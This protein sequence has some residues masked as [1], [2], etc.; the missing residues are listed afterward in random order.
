L[1]FKNIN[2]HKFDTTDMKKIILPVLLTF[3]TT[4]AYSQKIEKKGKAIS[5]NQPKLVI[6]IV[7][8][9]M[10][11]DYVYR[12]ADKFGEGGFNRL[13]SQGFECSNTNY[14]YVPTYTGPGHAAIYSGTVPYY[15]GIIANDWYE[16]K[17]GHKVYVT[18]DTT[19][20]TIGSNS[21]AGKMSPRR[22]LS[23]TITD[24][25][26][27]FNNKQSKVIGICLKDRG[28]ILPAGHFPHS[29]YWFD[30]KTGNWITSSYYTNELPTWVNRFNDK[31]LAEQYLSKPWNTLYPIAQYT[32]GLANGSPF[33]LPYKGEESNQFPH[34]LP[35]IMNKEGY[36]LLRSTPFGNSFTTDFAIET[37]AQE[38]LGKGNFT[39]FLALSF[40]STDYIG[41][42]FGI[43]AIETEDTYARLDK[44]LERFFRFVDSSIGIEN[45][46]IF[47]T[48][49][50]GAAQTPSQ[51]QSLNIPA[52]I[53]KS[54]KI[55][56]S[57]SKFISKQYGEANWVLHYDNQ[58]FW[59]NN[60]LLENK[61]LDRNKLIEICLN[62]L[63]KMEG[64]QDVFNTADLLNSNTTAGLVDHLIRGISPLRS[65]DILM[66]LQPGWFDAHYAANGGTTH[67][68]GHVYDTHVPLYWFGWHIKQ[69]ASSSPVFITDI[70][71]TLSDLLHI[72]RPNAC[73]GNP[74]TEMLIKK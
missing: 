23:T 22:L 8:D 46:L 12:F 13:L 73:I 42:Q 26:Q 74:L 16:R 48:A 24:E 54:H 43:N 32:V 65:G 34:D 38:K 70:A 31:K 68:S 58:Q 67:G 27:L 28:S 2:K 39:D 45:V 50:H 69:G 62:Y 66:T 60:S 25:L 30:N 64:V 49:D 59:L 61:K 20:K 14:N 10:R 41:H 7:V 9:Q 11:A 71:A 40:S 18:E 33:R 15:N 63:K 17:V 53:F 57:L 36:E 3:F 21:D 55:K 44:D 72:A 1:A 47:L 51:M 56:D 52:G 37:I 5:N 6:G 35:K 19:V 4:L 29:A